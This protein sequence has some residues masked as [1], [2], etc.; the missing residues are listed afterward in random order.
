MNTYHKMFREGQI[1]KSLSG[2]DIE[3]INM[4]GA[5]AQ[6]IVYKVK[7]RDK[8][9]ALKWY[10]VSDFSNRAEFYNNI[11]NNVN[12][13]PPADTFLW[14][15]EMTEFFED[16]YGYLM[17]L[18]PPE[19]KEF[20]QF[21]LAN[22]RFKSINAIIKAALEISRGFRALHAKG[23]SYQDL[24]DGNFFVDPNTGKLLICDNDN[25]APY[26]VNLGIAGKFRY[27]A[28]EIVTRKK[29]PD[30]HTDRFSLGIILYL[31]LFFT[32]PLEGKKTLSP[33]M[34]RELEYEFY[35][36]NPVFAWDINDD[37]NRPVAG[38][39]DNALRIWPLYPRFIQDR[40]H[41]IFSKESMIG[42]DMEHRVLERTWL[43]AFIQ[44]RDVTIFC[45]CGEE[46]FYN[47]E[48]PLNRCL[49]CGN[50][51]QK[52]PILKAKKFKVVLA[53]NKKVYACH[54]RYDSDDSREETGKVVQS[55]FNK[56]LVA[57]RNDSDVVWTVILT[58]GSSF[59]VENGQTLQMKSGTKI[60]FGNNNIGE[61][62]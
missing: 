6:G 31:L 20:S 21:L 1:I 23:F 55:K 15:L 53:P 57:L 17:E 42:S 11:Q 25:V 43:E 35:G 27:I 38:V 8:F 58:D 50:A 9:L 14:P 46:T 10:Y 62:I 52:M 16:S 56:D 60:D 22:V 40:F 49:V 44:L 48:T 30:V 19:F 47:L 29:M 51:V 54:T 4:L 59:T 13:G 12:E 5:G 39:H 37:S 34:T 33:C 32:H 36:S 24:N 26:G 18:R 28:P 7:Y 61:I 45:K 2:D 3:I 41:E